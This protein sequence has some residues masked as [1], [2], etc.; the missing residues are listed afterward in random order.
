MKRPAAAVASTAEPAK[1][2]RPVKRAKQPK[3]EKL[4]RNKPATHVEPETT[5]SEELADEA[6]EMD[7][8]DFEPLEQSM[9]EAALKH[10]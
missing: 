7:N 8:M 4:V 5:D 2:E 6:L 1:Q 9:L 3:Q 10:K